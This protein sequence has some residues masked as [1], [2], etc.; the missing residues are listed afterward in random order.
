MFRV[1]AAQDA[2]VFLD[3]RATLDRVLEY[4]ARAQAAD[5]DLLA[6]GETFFPGYPFW[7]AHTGG[8]RFD[9]PRQK[10][11]YR[12]YL[13]AAVR[14][15]GPEVVEIVRAVRDARTFV[16]LGVAERG[17]GPASGSVFC[18]LLAIHPEHGLV[19]HHR[20]LVPTYEERLV[21]AR[22]D[23]HGL[24]VH[25]FAG[26]RVSALNCWENWMP[27]P[28]YALYAQGAEVHVA[29]WPGAV[30]NTEDATRF[31]AREGRVF[32]LSAS[33]VL[34]RTDI[35][36]D[37][38]LKDVL[39]DQEWFHDGGSA[40]AGPDG[41]FVVEPV[42]RQRG[43]VQAQLDLTQVARER[44]NFDPTGHYARPDVFALE[45]DRHRQR[46]VEF[47]GHERAPT[48]SRA[49]PDRP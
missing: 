1:A 35:P 49:G 15:D 13:E 29:L 30:R 10:D 44:Q 38:A 26:T 21:W 19:G 5:V 47:T 40:V 43:L 18:T 4:L 27:L 9:D 34:A 33:G 46:P 8:A 23:G 2:P 39:P 6:F 25:E 36:D 31:V 45:V 12:Q 41:R 11:A 7:L 28:R 20:K 16:V 22:G 32:V 24:R 3:R 37:F 17:A 42:A 48:R 14:I